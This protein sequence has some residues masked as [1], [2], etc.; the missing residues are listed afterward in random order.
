MGSPKKPKVGNR[1]FYGVHL[2]PAR[3]ADAVL[4]IRMADKVVWEGDQ[5]DGFIDINDKE[6]FG[7][8]EREGGFSGRIAVMLG[9][10]TQT[11][12]TYLQGIFGAFTPA[13]Y[14]V[15]SMVFQRPY[16]N[17]NSARLPSI[18][19]KLCNVEDIHKGWLP[20]K[21]VVD[22]EG[23][24]NTAAIYI[25]MDV[26]LSM[27]GAPLATQGA[28]L[29]AFVRSM[30]G[31]TN[32][33]KVVAYSAGIN[34]S[35]E[36]LDCTDEDYEDVGS[37]IEDYTTLVTGGDWNAAV[38]QAA[39]FF[40]DD[41]ALE[42]DFDRGDFGNTIGGLFGGGAVSQRKRRI[43]VFTT[44]GAPVPGTPELAAATIAAIGGVEV[45]AFNI[46]DTDTTETEKI[47]NTPRDGVPV[48]PSSNPA[49]LRV[50]L[51]SAFRAWV[52][53]N[54]AHLQRCVLIDP[55][56]GGT[57]TADEIGDSFAVSA[58]AYLSEGFGLSVVFGGAEANIKDR[59]EIDRH[60]DAVTFKSRKTGKWEHKR[61]RDDFDFDDLPVL[62]GTVVKDWSKL[63]RP[64]QREL[65]NKLTVIYTDRANGKT[66]SVTHSNPV[67]VRAAGRTNKGQDARYPFVS[68]ATL[69][70]RLCI[71]DLTSGGTPL[72]AGDLP[73][74]YLPADFELSSIMRLSSPNPVVGDVAVRITELRHAGGVDAS[75]WL[76]VV[77]HRFDLS[78]G[79]TLPPPPVVVTDDRA[80]PATVR[81]VEEAPYYILALD[82][83]EDAVDDALAAEP[84]TGRVMVA[85]AAPNARHL[86]ATVGVDTGGGWT[87]DGTIGFVPV[88]TT[89]EDLAGEGDALTVRIAA[90]DGLA[91]VTAGQLAVIG[92]EILRVDD[93]VE[94]AG[95]ILMTIGR[96]CVDTVPQRHASGA[97]VL[98]INQGTPLD[99]DYLD[100]ESVDVKLLPRTASAILSLAAAPVDTVTFDS[101]AIRPYPPGRFKLSGAYTQDQFTAD[102]VLTWAHRDRTLQT[103]PVAEDHDDTDIGPEA[104]TTYRFRA[105]ALDGAGDVI[106]TVTDTNVG[107]VTTHDWDDSTA[108]PAGTVRVRFRVTSVRDG[109]ES[110]QSPALTMLVLLPP[111]DLEFEVL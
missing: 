20:D 82:A 76:K 68:I 19:I 61:V 27:A 89:L 66:A 70:D 85:A 32:S 34:A 65:P 64:K 9:K 51:L 98:F 54:P 83:G 74:A 39:D 25:A 75:V 90:N 45:F 17:A 1:Y 108:L 91:S 29:A 77:E 97:T 79:I 95:A 48:V 67:A 94:D 81:L 11:V 71:R 92:S 42:R 88:T 13:F 21:C 35:I 60:C 56:R 28:A 10:T 73:L 47:D 36:R 18:D 80:K 53:L 22:V 40:A 49:E 93:M 72:L 106:S 6:A 59:M 96:G 109:Y 107:G 33:L 2:I 103:T 99:T 100:G 14:G 30:V 69:A 46:D 44:D 37:W 111:G 16:F 58:D 23:V 110:W 26:S 87:D 15:M 62:D 104:G 55:M 7:G 8:D 3:K 50:A 101:R 84:G 38:A 63:R 24:V 5:G 12:N 57:A 52:D 31:K 43:I 86:E 102:A 4:A 41:D 78:D 105:D